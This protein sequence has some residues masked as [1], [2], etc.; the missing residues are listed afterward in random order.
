[1]CQSG[2]FLEWALADPMLAPCRMW[3]PSSGIAVVWASE[4][5]GWVK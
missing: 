4:I 1:V 5:G 3:A 2:R